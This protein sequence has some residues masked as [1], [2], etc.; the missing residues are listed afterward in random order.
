MGAKF[1]QHIFLFISWF[2]DGILNIDI[3]IRYANF[4]NIDIKKEVF[5]NIHINEILLKYAYR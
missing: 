3:N 4:K 2:V 1:G 5:K